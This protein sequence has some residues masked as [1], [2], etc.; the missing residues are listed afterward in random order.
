M[1]DACQHQPS[2]ALRHKAEPAPFKHPKLCTAFVEKTL[3][4]F[5][6][7]GDSTS[8]H[9]TVT[10]NTAVPFLSNAA[11]LLLQN[12]ATD[13]I[14]P[15]R[16]WLPARSHVVKRSKTDKPHYFYTKQTCATPR[17]DH[18]LALRTKNWPAC[19]LNMF[20]GTELRHTAWSRCFCGVTTHV[21]VSLWASGVINTPLNCSFGLL[22]H[23]RGRESGV[24]ITAGLYPDKLTI[25]PQDLSG[26]FT[27][28][29]GSVWSVRVMKF[30]SFL[31]V[32]FRCI[33]THRFKYQWFNRLL[34][35][36]LTALLTPYQ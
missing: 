20:T 26:S 23:S 17:T 4:D 36:R 11:I 28:F 14:G 19:N 16:H 22:K 7:I 21:C 29:W 3:H 10:P 12:K 31:T 27:S 6:I 33:V 5:H 35:K 25:H 13:L 30:I 32:K 24:F 2:T 1:T 9:P 34:D 18:F 8:E 15:R